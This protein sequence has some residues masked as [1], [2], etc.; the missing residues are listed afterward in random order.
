MNLTETRWGH[1]DWIHLGQYRDK[2][3]ESSYVHGNE[4]SGCKKCWEML[5]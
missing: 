2:L 5:E 4:H 3:A 1:M